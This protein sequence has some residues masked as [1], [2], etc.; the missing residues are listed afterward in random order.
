MIRQME[1]VTLTE[2]LW[3]RQCGCCEMIRK[4]PRYENSRLVWDY[5][6]KCGRTETHFEMY[7]RTIYVEREYDPGRS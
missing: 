7:P 6:C 5:Y 4:D 3:C 2:Y 1:Q